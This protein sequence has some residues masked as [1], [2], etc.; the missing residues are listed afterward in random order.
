[1]G[2]KL[3]Q[4][5]GGRNEAD[6]IDRAKSAACAAMAKAAK[7]LE[8]AAARVGDFDAIER[9]AATAPRLA[10]AQA[11]A[12]QKGVK[13]PPATA[14]TKVISGRSAALA[15]MSRACKALSQRLAPLA[16]RGGRPT[17]D[18]WVRET[19]AELDAFGFSCRDS[20][21]W[22]TQLGYPISGSQVKDLLDLKKMPR[23]AP[24]AGSIAKGIV[25]LMPP[26]KVA[27]ALR[28]MADRMRSAKN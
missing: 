16:K 9:E 3:Q 26:P 14:P 13:V 1:M 10:L 19:L 11:L 6:R 2:R 17:R 23:A 12:K 18:A 20:A 21:G 24:Q 8:V 4:P 7:A 25:A 15:S 28:A 5:Q 27:Q 22:L